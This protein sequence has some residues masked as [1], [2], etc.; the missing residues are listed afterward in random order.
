MEISRFIC[1]AVK[2]AN[3]EDE[4]ELSADI[5]EFGYIIHIKI[6]IHPRVFDLALCDSNRARSKIHPCDLPSGFGE[7]DDIRACTTAEVNRVASGMSLDEVKKFRR[8]DSAV[9]GWFAKIPEV[10]DESLE[11]FHLKI[12]RITDDVIRN[13]YLLSLLPQRV[14]HFLCVEFSNCAPEFIALRIK[15]NK[16]RGKV[17]AVNRS[18]VLADLFLNIQADEEDLTFQFFFE[19]VN[20]GLCGGTANSVR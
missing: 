16:S 20:D 4:I 12:L 13:P 7:R 6:R 15:E 17:K 19:L 11:K 18:Q 8:C 1:Y 10:E 5:F 9:P 14:A 2:T 3:V